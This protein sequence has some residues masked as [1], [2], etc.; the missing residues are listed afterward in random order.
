MILYWLIICRLTLIERYLNYIQYKEQCVFVFNGIYSL[1]FWWGI[2]TMFNIKRYERGVTIIWIILY[3]LVSSL[4]LFLISTWQETSY[5]HGYVPLVVSTSLSLPHSWLITGF[6]SRLT[7]RGSL[8]EKELLTFPSIW[9]HPR[10]LVLFLLLDRYFY[11][12]DTKG[13]IISRTWKDRQHNCQ[14]FENTKRIII[15]PKWK[16]RQHNGQMFENTKGV[17]R[18]RKS[19]K[20]R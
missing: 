16:D 8:A 7:L 6:V 14:M 1:N 12:L 3:T 13:I 9:V 4:V 5:D 11:V 15:S 17:I 2:S 20:D 18:T 19:K 10:F